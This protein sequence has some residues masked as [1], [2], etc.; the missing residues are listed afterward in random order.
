[1]F[2]SSFTVN[3]RNVEKRKRCPLC[4]EVMDSVLEL[5]DHLARKHDMK[6][7]KCAHCGAKFRELDQM[8]LH[9]AKRHKFQIAK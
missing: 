6:V 2:F 8:A 4:K 5:K 7:H 9:V 3:E 1:M